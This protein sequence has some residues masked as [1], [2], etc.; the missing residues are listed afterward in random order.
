MAAFRSPFPLAARCAPEMT[1]RAPIPPP[2]PAG[3]ALMKFTPDDDFYDEADTADLPDC[4]VALLARAGSWSARKL[5]NGFVPASMLAQLSSDPV[6]A[7]EELCRRGIWR[8]AKRGGYQFTRWTRWGETAADTGRREAE[9]ERR[10]EQGRLRSQRKRD[11]DK[12]ALAAAIEAGVTAPSRGQTP[13]VTLEKRNDQEESQVNEAAVT[14]YGSVAQRVTAETGASDYQD[15]NQSPGVNQSDA[16]ARE[17]PS[18]VTLA[19]V[20]AGIAKKLKRIVSEAEA[21]RAVAVWDRRAEAAGEVIHDPLKYYGTC[22]R[23]ARDLEV[24]IAPPLPAP[25]P[26]WLDLGSA[27]P[28]PPGAHVYQPDGRRSVDCCTHPGCGLKEKNARHVKQEAGTG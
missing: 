28:P 11:R 18:P 9:A 24:I 14:R 15:Q 10:R 19:F 7:A 26:E 1:C 13:A 21:C 12:A 27:P 22:I 20:V 23:R 4:A 5:K 6:R 2:L 25:P 16:R 17:A 3:T 8:R